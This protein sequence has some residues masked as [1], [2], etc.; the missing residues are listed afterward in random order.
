MSSPPGSP[1][2]PSPG[3]TGPSGSDFDVPRWLLVALALLVG[4]AAVVSVIEV[5]KLLGGDEAAGPEHP[6]TW[7]ARVL[8]LVERVEKLRGLEFEQPVYVD[9]LPVKEFR[10]KV[11]ADEKDLDDEARE[12]IEQG[13]A[14]MRAVG[15]LE[16]DLDLLD[17][18][19]DLHSGGTLGYYAFED[20]RITIRGTRLTWAIRSTLVHELT[21]ALQDQHFDIGT[22]SK[23]LEDDEDD[24]PSAMAFESLVEGDA[25]RI[26]QK[27]S[28]SL[29]RKQRKALRAS[30][31]AQT[32][33]AESD[34]EDV[35]E[36]LTT[37]IGA[38][39]ALGEALM[40]S[41]GTSNARVD[42]LFRLP[43]TTEEHLLDP[44]T[45][46]LDEEGQAGV[47][48]PAVKDGEKEVDSSTFGAVGWYLVLA[49]RIPV[50]EALRAVDGWGG[51][52]YVHVERKGRQ[53]VRVGYVADTKRD[54]GEMY[55][56]LKA[57]VAAT[58]R[59]AS[60]SRSGDQLTFE[61]CDPGRKARVGRQQS[62]EA[63]QLA[64]NRT[65]L[66]VQ[67][68][69]DVNAKVARCLAGGLVQDFSSAELQ[70]E[71]LDAEQQQRVAAIRG[72]CL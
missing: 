48:K 1:A 49:E 59:T 60:V 71:Q 20:E 65:W 5:R 47:D 72:R 12:E 7:D 32:D 40:A 8:P 61:S 31:K 33:K 18:I 29:N 43:P 57:W 11:T 28:E 27:W 17:S 67:I 62:E 4:V 45:L 66:T 6:D 3:P 68:R 42:K 63:L 70:V 53:C 24:N 25:R 51:D 58:P 15:V 22:R 39:Y 19:N 44:F 13:T 50:K 21:H 26:E 41:A 69:E 38:S 46:L 10:K 23:R 56:A 55:T 14:F 16:G 36:F 54:L 34:L 35:P 9:F 30:E 64:L 52:S 2:P 37:L